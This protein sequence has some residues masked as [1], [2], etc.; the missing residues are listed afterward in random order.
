[1]DDYSTLGELTDFI[2]AQAA[3]CG[4]VWMILNKRT[5]A[6]AISRRLPDSLR[7]LLE[8]YKA[9]RTVQRSQSKPRR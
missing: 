3:F 8:L 6:Q 7:M 4:I 1:M 5:C 2:V 9:R